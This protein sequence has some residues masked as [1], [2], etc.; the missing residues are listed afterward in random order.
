MSKRTKLS[1]AAKKKGWLKF[2]LFMLVLT[3]LIFA[4][5]FVTFAHKVDNLRPPLNI[6]W[7]RFVAPKQRR[8]APY[9]RGQRQ[10]ITRRD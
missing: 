1:P 7:G 4:A 8:A 9:L 6:A 10:D 2:A 5:G 3:L